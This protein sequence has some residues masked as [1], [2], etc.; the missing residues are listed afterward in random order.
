MPR[1]RRPSSR[2]SRERGG[3]QV[4]QIVVA[5]A[6]PPTH[7]GGTRRCDCGHACAAAVQP[8]AV[9]RHAEGRW[10][11]RAG[12]SSARQCR[13]GARPLF[14]ADR[15]RPVCQITQKQGLQSS[16][17]RCLMTGAA[18]TAKQQSTCAGYGT[19]NTITPLLDKTQQAHPSP[20]R[21]T[22]GQY[23]TRRL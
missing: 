12:I 2:P 5:S 8:R 11:R 1:P 14:P 16:S 17:G 4:G 20:S 15:C 13:R 22:R 3:V 21:V 7:T 6:S 10:K 23:K 9:G 19:T 18:P